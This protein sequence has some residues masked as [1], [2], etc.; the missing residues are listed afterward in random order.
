MPSC[1]LL[2]QLITESAGLHV[3]GC[4]TRRPPL[5]ALG[6]NMSR[7]PFNRQCIAHARYSGRL[8]K[9][10]SMLVTLYGGLVAVVT[11]LYTNRS[12]LWVGQVS[13]ESRQEC[14]RKLPAAQ[15]T[16]MSSRPKR[17]VASCTHRSQSAAFLTSPCMHSEVSPRHLCKL[18]PPLPLCL[19]LVSVPEG[20]HG[21]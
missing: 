14:T 16:R 1:D 2:T 18:L 9:A 12:G 10:V 21:V 13:R 20:P 17:V 3:L 7:T 5:S 4:N 15:L 19:P 8:P 11:G 6:D